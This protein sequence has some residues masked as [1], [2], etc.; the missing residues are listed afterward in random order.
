MDEAFIL[1]TV[2][3]LYLQTLSMQNLLESLRDNDNEVNALRTQV[4]EL[5]VALAKSNESRAEE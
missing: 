2:G 4:N 1:Q 3:R 5:T